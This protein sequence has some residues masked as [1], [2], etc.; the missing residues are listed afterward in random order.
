MNW[1]IATALKFSGANWI[2]EKINSWKTKIAATGL[3]L[4]GAS[5]MLAGASSIVM[6]LY[7][8]G[9]MTCVVE[10]ARS[11][12]DNPNAKTLME[13]FVVFNT[14]LGALGI[15]HKIQK[16]IDAPVVVASA[17]DPNEAVRG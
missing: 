1:L 5:M 11:L 4:S 10:L 15:G 2:W 9:N 12:T 17:V 13:G 7:A 3:M 14:G 6:T 16:S 8:C